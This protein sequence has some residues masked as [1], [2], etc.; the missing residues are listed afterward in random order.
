MNNNQKHQRDCLEPNELPELHA[1]IGIWKRGLKSYYLKRSENM[2][3]YPSVWS[4]FSIQFNPVQLPDPSDLVQAQSIMDLISAERL[5]GAPTKV[6]EYLTSDDSDTNPINTH[7]FLHLYLVELDTEPELNPDYYEEGA[8]LTFD[9]FEE[10]T[11]ESGCGSCTRMWWDHAFLRR[12]VQRPFPT[13]EY[14]S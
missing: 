4:L 2:E 7:V 12:W 6:I 5:N 1:I 3:N 11:R 14:E 10:K 9:E 13:K 8:W